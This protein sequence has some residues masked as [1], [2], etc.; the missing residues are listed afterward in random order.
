MALTKAF[1]EA[2]NQNNIRRIRIMMKDSLLVDPTFEEF[3]EMKNV[4]K[5]VDGLY[6]VHDGRS[7]ESDE[8]FWNDDYM[9]KQMVQLIGNFSKERIE[10]IKDVV[11]CLRRDLINSNQTKNKVSNIVS[12]PTKNMSYEEQKH[13]DQINGRY[14]GAK[15]ATGAAVGAVAGGVIASTAGVTVLGGAV[16]GA[17]V[18]GVAVA[19]L[20]NGG[21]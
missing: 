9:N 4:A 13:Y 11:H 15:I 10:H 2:V 1:Y 19:A 21:K 18:G 6:D 8:T 14:R 7:F 20:T 17:V 3:N 16:A 12:E 5:S